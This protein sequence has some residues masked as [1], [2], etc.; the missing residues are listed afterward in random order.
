MSGSTAGD[1]Y[2][3]AGPARGAQ[4]KH[5]R[6]SWITGRPPS[7]LRR[8]PI[9]S[10]LAVASVMFWLS[11]LPVLLLGASPRV[12]SSVGAILGLALPA[13][14]ITAATEGRVGVRD[15]LRRA[16]RWRVGLGWYVVAALAIPVGALLLAPLLP[17]AAPL[18]R[19]GASLPLLFTAFLPQLLVALVTV[20]FFEELGWAGF[21][22]HQLQARH[23][24]LTASLLLGMAFAFLHLPT[25]LSVPVSASSAVQDLTV[26]VVVLPFA[27][28][29]RILIAYAYNRTA[30]AVLIAAVTH[31]S[32]NESSELISPN[33]PGAWG[34]VLAFASVGLLALLALGA[35]RGTLASS[36]PHGVV[37]I[38]SGAPLPGPSQADATTNREGAV[39]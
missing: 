38:A 25:Y 22:Q 12:F 6:R 31:A 39:R 26:L 17:G 3:A 1:P 27:I 30:S 36:R 10:F 16:L 28:T 8:H 37:L 9:T 24:A 7:F 11:W 4:Q 35:S 2:L 20:Q 29:F 5:P 19:L 21:V 23:G 13:I 33:V 34:Q 15:L 18:E 14:L 32:F